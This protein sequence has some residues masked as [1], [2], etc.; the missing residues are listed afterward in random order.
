[1]LSGCCQSHSSCQSVYDHKVQYHALVTSHMV[2]DLVTIFG[3]GSDNPDMNLFWA[4][5]A[6]MPSTHLNPP[7]RELMGSLMHVI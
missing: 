6:M 5:W 4:S 2:L 3:R 1:M 7:C